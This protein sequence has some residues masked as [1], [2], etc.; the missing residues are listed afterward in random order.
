[1]DADS[2]AYQNGKAIATSDSPN[3]MYLSAVL[4]NR[5]PRIATT[6]AQTAFKSA[7]H[8][9]TLPAR[10]KLLYFLDNRRYG[11]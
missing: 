5:L 9:F 10:V 4:L 1:M 6:K 3:A 8:S 7:L 2:C 11:L